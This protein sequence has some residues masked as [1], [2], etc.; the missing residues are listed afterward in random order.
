M[1]PPMLHAGHFQRAYERFWRNPHATSLLWISILFS[2][3]STSMFQQKSRAAALG[4]Q[5]APPPWPSPADRIAAFSTMAYRCLEAGEYLAGKP[6]SVEA[7]LLYGMHL[8]LQKRDVD[9]VCWHMLSTAVRLAQRMG[10]HRDASHLARDVEPALSA[11][12]AEMRRRTWYTLEYFDVVYSFQLG[13]PP[14]IQPSDVDTCLPANLRD[15]EFDE[16]DSEH[17]NGD[18]RLQQKLDRARHPASSSSSLLEFTPILGFIYYARQIQ[19]LRRVVQQALAVNPPPTYGDVR[20]LDA[21]LRALHADIPPS[22]RYRPVRES[23]FA[24]SPDVIMR[25]LVCEVMYLK[26]LCVLHRR[27]LLRGWT[28]TPANADFGASSVGGVYAASRRTCCEAALGLLDLQAEFDEHSSEPGARLY[29][30]RYILTN[31]GYHDF[32]LAVMCLCLD[33]TAATGDG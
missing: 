8:V 19:L 7:T 10:Y 28:G 24:D 17:H 21:D 16:L 15:D 18:Q 9:P 2:L 13:V 22:L 26:S 27:Y 14:V 30:R 6:H 5:T 32:L 12:E 23:G 4:Q 11:F 25:R 20:R 31:T 3:L 29:E 33:L 1:V